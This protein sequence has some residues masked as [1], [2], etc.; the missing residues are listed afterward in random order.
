MRFA[1]VVLAGGAARRLGG[2]P[3][4]ART[5]AGVPLLTR[6]LDAVAAADV[7][8]VVG[9]PWPTCPAGLPAPAR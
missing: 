8:V 7:R 2:A 9:P 5:V 4:P 6:V 3:K 1:A